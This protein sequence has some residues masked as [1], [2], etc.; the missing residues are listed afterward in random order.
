MRIS[1]EDI[2]WGFV[3]Q[4][5]IERKLADTFQARH[6]EYIMNN[7]YI[8][9]YISLIFSKETQM[10]AIFG[11]SPKWLK[12]VTHLRWSILQKTWYEMFDRVLNEPLS[13]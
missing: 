8:Y 3:A 13:G 11:D 9:I 5:Y 10:L 2:F 12:P 1:G 6:N 7:E 4:S